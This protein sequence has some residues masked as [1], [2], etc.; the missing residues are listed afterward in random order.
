M[1]EPR[2]RE[3]KVRPQEKMRADVRKSAASPRR[4]SARDRFAAYWLHHRQVARDSLLRLLRNPF[5]SLATWFMIGIAL[6]LPGALYLMLDNVAQLGGRWDGA[7]QISVFLQQDLDE[8]AGNALQQRI[9]QLPGV[10]HAEYISREQALA[11][12]RSIS[13]FGEVIDHLDA[14]P[15]PAVISVRPMVVQ[16][17]GAAAVEKLFGQI[18]AL[19]GVE[20]AVLD[21]AWVQKLYAILDVGQHL[22]LALAAML[23]VGVILVIGNTIRLAIESRRDEILVVKLVG[24]TDAFVRRPFL[25][26][27]F[28]F[29]LGGG[30][31]AWAMLAAS[32]SW[33]GGPVAQ[34]ASLYHSDFALSGLGIAQVAGLLLIGSVL[35]WC[36]A[37]GAV[38]RHLGAIEPR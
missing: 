31:A 38:R 2:Y 30:V 12:F 24:G 25:Y 27:G 5:G 29:G 13:G 35:G 14:N 18:K 8:A 37:W 4:I 21:L 26:T 32:L 28:W 19:P 22:A 9:A 34:L 36:G 11:E 10:T 15:L 33:L 16:G 6:A 1:A 20:R 3:E 7:P 23:G 17:G